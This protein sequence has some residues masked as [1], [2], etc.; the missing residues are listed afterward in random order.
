MRLSLCPPPVPPHFRSTWYTRSYKHCLKKALPFCSDLPSTRTGAVN[1]DPANTVDRVVR[2]LTVAGVGEMGSSAC[3]AC[4]GVLWRADTALL[5][6]PAPCGGEFEPA[7]HPPPL[8]LDS[9]IERRK[10]ALEWHFPIRIPGQLVHVAISPRPLATTRTYNCERDV[11]FIITKICVV[12]LGSYRAM[13][14]SEAGSIKWAGAVCIPTS[15]SHVNCR[16]VLSRVSNAFCVAVLQPFSMHRSVLQYSCVRGQSCSHRRGMGAVLYMTACFRLPRNVVVVPSSGLRQPLVP[17]F[18]SRYCCEQ[19][20]IP[21][22]VAWSEVLK[23]S[24]C[25]RACIILSPQPPPTHAHGSN[26]ACVCAGIH[27][28]VASRAQLVSVGCLP[29]AALT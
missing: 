27:A 2:Y 5:L 13:L 20:A 1:D 16:H 12:L 25:T 8:R 6:L 23:C 11:I 15:K 18:T 14:P 9:C 28:V 29:P 3:R 21:S 4:A 26:C 22:A 17:Q 19:T 24:C 7:E 10:P